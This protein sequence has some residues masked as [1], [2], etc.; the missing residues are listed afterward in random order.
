M[1]SPLPRSTQETLEFPKAVPLA[2]GKSTKKSLNYNA[3]TNLLTAYPR[4]KVADCRCGS[5]QG[6][7]YSQ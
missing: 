6:K 3:K 7:K 4:H 2:Q 5:H 1:D